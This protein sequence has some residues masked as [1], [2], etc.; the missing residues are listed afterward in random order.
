M[1]YEGSICFYVAQYG[2]DEWTG[3][4]PQ[5]DSAGNDGPF[6]T[7]KKAVE[8][9]RKV[10][11][12]EPRRIILRGGSY[13]NTFLELTAEDSGLA[14]EAMPG[15][16]PILYGGKRITGWKKE[17]NGDF[18]FAE[19]PEAASGEWN[20]RMLAVNRRFCKR[21]RL[22]EKGTYSHLTEFDV[23]W[24]STTEG[25][26]KRKPTMDELTAFQY[27][28][29]DLGPWL[30]CKS[31]ELT[32][33]HKWDESLA[34]IAT[35][36]VENHSFRLSNPCGH[37]PGAFGYKGYI[38]WNVREGMTEPGQWYLDRTKG[39][40]V[41]W[42][43]TGEDMGKAEV[44]APTGDTVLN[45]VEKV[46][47]VTMKGL[48]LSA[49]NTPLIA[50]EFGAIRMPGAVQSLEGLENCLFSDLTIENTAGHGFKFDGSNRTV[51]IVGCEVSNTGAGGIVFYNKMS[52]S[53]GN[54]IQT[55]APILSAGIEQNE[56]DCM[57]ENNLVHHVGLLYPSAIGI[58]A[59]HCNIVHNEIHDTTYTGICYGRGSDRIEYNLVSRAMQ[60]LND[61]AAI[62]VTFSKNG[63]IRGNVIKDIQQSSDSDST[64]NAI[65][66]D[67][68]AS[69][70]VVEDNLVMNCTHPTMN[71]MA[72]GNI[73][74][75]NVFISDSY[76]K[77][78]FIRCRD[79]KVD[80]NILYSKGKI[81]FAGN[82]DAVASCG[83]NV[84]YSLTGEYEE[85]HIDD[86]YHLTGIVPLE[87]RKGT[88]K[89]DPL[90]VDA[91]KDNYAFREGSP[92]FKLGIEPLQA[93]M[94]GRRK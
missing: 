49:T 45:F 39:R 92:A 57:I 51:R 25:G 73:F 8:A 71:H 4:L 31:A 40:V 24:M 5:P 7:L 9:A 43:V 42:P 65:Y 20:F 90:F 19:L 36:D 46:K 34:G 63:I 84:I 69:G 23:P 18:W 28:E 72:H 53:A 89:A 22:P 21:S 56:P 11:N 78:N 29:S 12:G 68:Q 1:D 27:K 54:N 6:A 60:V 16:T 93:D 52:E 67:E 64:R 76:L 66:L 38:V 44:V 55:A 13:Y 2:C 50:G 59:H 14:I 48:V 62:Y 26:W 88:V 35:H 83:N 37:P 58:A 32:I 33:F 10:R 70:W 75:N 79:Y 41:Y 85:N 80:G 86:K 15:E 81:I 91:S 87:V 77:M 3:K 61:G 82:P 74:R 47:D 30:D 17:E 94:A